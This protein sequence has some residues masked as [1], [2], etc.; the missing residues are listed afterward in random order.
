MYSC[1]SGRK[2]EKAESREM[3]GRTSPAISET[4]REA[5]VNG[6]DQEGGGSRHTGAKW[7]ERQRGGWQ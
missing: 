3:H 4:F 1:G 6:M 5:P 7:Q 2:A